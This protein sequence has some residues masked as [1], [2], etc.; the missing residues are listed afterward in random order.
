[1]SVLAAAALTAALV[2]APAVTT[3]TDTPKPPPSVIS[4]CAATGQEAVDALLK[5]VATSD[6]VGSL[7][8]L[9]SIVVVDSDTPTLVDSVQLSKARTALN[10]DALATTTT[11]PTTTTAPPSTSS[12]PLTTSSKVP[13]T[14]NDQVSKVPTGGVETGDGSTESTGAG[15]AALGALV[16]AAAALGVPGLRRSLNRR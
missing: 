5:G 14:G 10:C 15:W 11:T 16:A 2:A 13:D 4:L 7:K 1:M 3:T 12:V 6:L 9:A 8:P